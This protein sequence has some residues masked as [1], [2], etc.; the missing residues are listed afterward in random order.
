[1]TQLNGGEGLWYAAGVVYFTTKGDR[2]VWGYTPASQTIEVLYDAALAP[3]ASLDA[4]DN[5]T[6][7]AAGDVLVRETAATSSSASSAP[8]GRRSAVALHRSAAPG[9]A[10]LDA[11]PCGPK[12]GCR[13]RGDAR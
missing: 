9:P 10:R 5:V 6:V 2:K 7:S 12:P 13:I 3:G 11:Q 4:V 1:M 8:T